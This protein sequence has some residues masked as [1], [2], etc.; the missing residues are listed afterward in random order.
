MA[1]NIKGKAVKAKRIGDLQKVENQKKYPSAA[2]EYNHI[3]VQLE[4]GREIHLLFTDKEV[5][6][7]DE[8]AKKNPED[9]PKTSW[10][11]DI[12]D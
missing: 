12:L 9:L 11:R 7:A 1:K 4:D 2:L 8:R 3:R 5:A 10:L 6:R